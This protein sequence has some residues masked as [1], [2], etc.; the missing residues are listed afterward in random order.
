MSNCNVQ[1]K[2]SKS[3]WLLLVR[4]CRHFPEKDKLTKEGLNIDGELLDVSKKCG[5]KRPKKTQL[6]EL[7]DQMNTAH[8]ELKR[9][10][11]KDER[12]V[13]IL[14]TVSRL[15]VLGCAPPYAAYLLISCPNL[16][17]K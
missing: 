8:D 9:L 10:V 17:I 14:T 13:H 6:D 5:S 12:C 4:V 7:K 2:T 11:N 16:C 1:L 3:S 15:S